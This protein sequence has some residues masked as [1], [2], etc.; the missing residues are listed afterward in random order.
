MKRRQLT[1]INWIEI[2][3]GLLPVSIPFFCFILP[4]VTFF[5]VV[6]GFSPSTFTVPLPWWLLGSFAGL[7]AVWCA[8][9]F[10][11]T[12]ITANRR[13][14]RCVR[15][16]LII[17][18]ITAVWMG[19]DLLGPFAGQLRLDWSILIWSLWLGGP[20]VV[21]VRHF[22]LL[23]RVSKMPPTQREA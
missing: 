13:M 2:V 10:S 6:T 1:L 14:Y 5:I 18:F 9:L 16:G 12:S 7:C 21:G 19:V 15:V 4:L 3:L 20:I 17:G 11:P 8:V 22:R 23:V